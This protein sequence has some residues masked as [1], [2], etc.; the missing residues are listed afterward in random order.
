MD[1]QGWSWSTYCETPEW[2][3]ERFYAKL[4]KDQEDRKTDAT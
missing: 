1:V 3:L 4:V 2:V